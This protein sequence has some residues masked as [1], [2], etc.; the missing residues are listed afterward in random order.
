MK[1]KI[2]IWMTWLLYLSTASIAGE[3]APDQKPVR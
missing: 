1:M 2:I 3:D